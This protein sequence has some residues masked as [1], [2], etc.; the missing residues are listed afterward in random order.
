MIAERGRVDMDEA[1]S[2]LRAFA[3]NNNRGLS[4]VAESLVAGTINIDSLAQVRRPP[5]PPTRRS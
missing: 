1:F 3:R 2:R 4:E 5:P